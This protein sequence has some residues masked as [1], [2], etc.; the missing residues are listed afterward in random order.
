MREAKAH[1][2]VDLAGLELL[3]VNTFH[4]E[5]VQVV[6]ERRVSLDA[7]H[8]SPHLLSCPSNLNTPNSRPPSPPSPQIS[9]NVAVF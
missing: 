3:E 5:K 8:A 4:G 7:C 1:A 2:E 9:T 6:R